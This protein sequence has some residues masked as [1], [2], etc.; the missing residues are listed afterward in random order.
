MTDAPASRSTAGLWLGLVRATSRMRRSR[1]RRPPGDRVHP[2]KDE[3]RE[4]HDARTWQCAICGE[5]HVGLATVFGPPTPDAWMEANDRQRRNGDINDDTCALPD[6]HGGGSLFIR[7]HIIIKA[8]ELE[9]GQFIWSVWVE[10]SP[11][12]MALTESHW[13]DPRR[14]ELLP[15]AGVLATDLPYPEPTRGLGVRVFTRPPGV[16]PFVK[17][18]RDQKHLIVEEQ[19]QG[20]S[21]HRVAEL[22]DALL[23]DY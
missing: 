18:N 19:R 16:V 11:E 12:D 14:D 20:I 15:M 22:N 2:V 6:G 7:G 1:H 23:A 21:L 4:P 13:H 5:P 8:P 17:L 10:I 3:D 9:T